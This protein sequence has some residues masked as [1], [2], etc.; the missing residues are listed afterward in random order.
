[1]INPND[2]TTVRVGQLPAEPWSGTDNL[3]HEVGTD[4]KRGT[5]ADLATYIAG[6]ID[7]SAGLAFNPLKI[8]DGQT[9]SV[10]TENEWIIVGR[11]TY[12]QSG[13]FANVVCVEDIN[14]VLSNGTSWGLGF[15]ITI[16]GVDTSDFVKLLE[17]QTIDGIKT[18][19]QSPIVPTATQPNEAVN[20]GQLAG[21]GGGVIDK[22]YSE[23]QTLIT[24]SG[25]VK[26]Q[27]Y[28][29]TDYMTTYTQ[30][31]TSVA[32]SSG[33]VEVL[34][35][36]ATDVNKLHNVCK[37]ELYPQDIVY[38]NINDNT[39]GFTKG[40]IFRRIDTI[41]NNDIGTDWR[42]VKYFRNGID[43]LLFE[44]YSNCYNNEI[45]TYT[46][47]DSVVGVGFYSNTIGDGFNS[48]TI[49][50]G[51]IY[52]TIRIIFAS[53]TIGDYFAFNTIGD[54]FIY[55]TIGS[56]F[57]FNT[58]G[59]GFASNAIGS[60][61]ASNAIASN[62]IYNTIGDGFIYNTIGNGFENQSTS[63]I[64]YKVFWQD[65]DVTVKSLKVLNKPQI[66]DNIQSTVT[67][68]E[69]ETVLKI[70]EI[71]AN[72]MEDGDVF[73]FIPTIT[74]NGAPTIIA[75]VSDVNDFTTGS[76]N[77]VSI[78]IFFGNGG[79]SGVDFMMKLKGTTLVFTD[80]NTS[81]YGGNQSDEQRLNFDRTVPN[82]IIITVS[83][84]LSQTTTLDYAILKKIN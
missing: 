69:V 72:F 51:F 65:N 83:Q 19:A 76:P 74:T 40:K 25:L 54:Y 11:G 13:G 46:L 6:I 8:S 80:N 5:V 16:D 27:V 20:L 12:L 36:T 78:F 58:I 41:K 61:F 50:D 68:V 35:I 42:H 37:S 23:L 1:M 15:G 63:N 64:S 56:S 48:N 24:T 82:Y 9:L 26:G 81:K 18:F 45:K 57:S 70:V 28:R 84:A 30:P 77:F 59:N 2:I 31:V 49:G 55:N 21:I 14:I 17:N 34:Y 32:K 10:T 7:G 33:I 29:L 44:V 47:M 79:F 52:N 66:Q 22:T 73:E 67:G 71:P 43:T 38:Y 39:E 60:N 3:P 53:N 75:Y 62:F 4:L